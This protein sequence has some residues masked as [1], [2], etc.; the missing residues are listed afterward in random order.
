MM[1]DDT[2][3]AGKHTVG[4][5]LVDEALRVFQLLEN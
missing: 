4:V 2:L 5:R 3:P 1:F